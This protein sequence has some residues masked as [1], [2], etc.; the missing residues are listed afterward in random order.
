MTAADVA[1]FEAIAGELLDELG[2]GRGAPPP[3]VRRRA[4]RSRPHRRRRRVPLVGPG[5]RRRP[6]RRP[7]G[8]P[9]MT[10]ASVAGFE[11][12][13]YEPATRPPCSTCSARRSAGSP[14]SCTPACSPG[15]TARTRSASRRRGSRPSP[16]QVVGFRTFLRWEFVVDGRAGAGGAGRRHRHPSRPPGPGRVRRPD[17]ARP[18]RAARRR[19][20]VRVQHAQRAA[21]APAT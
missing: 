14:T 13:R 6:R 11:V 16:T 21:A 4:Q 17:R 8:R 15:S 3:S 2:Y 7:P 19:R 9:P 18:R 12:R 1:R 10:S 20:G 5:G